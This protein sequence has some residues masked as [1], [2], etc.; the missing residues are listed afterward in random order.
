MADFLKQA[1]LVCH[2]TTY[3]KDWNIFCTEGPDKIDCSLFPSQK[4]NAQYLWDF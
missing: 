2:K 3:V 1:S 4:M